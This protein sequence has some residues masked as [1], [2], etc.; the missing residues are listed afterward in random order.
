MQ[1]RDHLWTIAQLEA[2]KKHLQEQV[3]GLEAQLCAQRCL[4][5]S[6]LVSSDFV[7]ERSQPSV[8]PVEGRTDN[9]VGGDCGEFLR[10]PVTSDRCPAPTPTSASVAPATVE[11]FIF[12]IYIFVRKMVISY[13]CIGLGTDLFC[14]SYFFILISKL[15]FSGPF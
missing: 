15:C 4:S 9:I 7:N 5:A 14:R 10:P 13:V 2:Q 8:L 12:N 1:C 11:L 6:S 3:R